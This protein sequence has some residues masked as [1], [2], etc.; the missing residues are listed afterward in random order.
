MTCEVATRT[1]VP[2]EATGMPG[3]E[4]AASRRQGTPL[5]MVRRVAGLAE[6]EV[7]STLFWSINAC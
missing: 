5:A 2:V 1:A 4:N 3:R 6:A 7:T